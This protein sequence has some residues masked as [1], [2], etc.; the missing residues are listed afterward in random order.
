MAQTVAIEKF[1]N[2]FSVGDKLDRTKYRALRY[3]ATNCKRAIA[4]VSR[5]KSLRPSRY[6]WNQ[7]TTK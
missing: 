6:D 1:H 4:I 5:H 2:I 7:E 3:T